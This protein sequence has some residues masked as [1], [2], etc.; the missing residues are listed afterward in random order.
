MLTAYYA[1]IV[2][3]Y[4]D[5]IRNYLLSLLFVTRTTMVA[6]T[7]ILK[8]R[9]QNNLDKS[10]GRDL[11]CHLECLVSVSVLVL[12]L[13]PNVTARSQNQNL[14]LD[15]IWRPKFRRLCPSVSRHAYL[16]IHTSEFHQIFCACHGCGSLLFWQCC[17]ML[18][19]SGFAAHVT[20]APNGQEWARR[21]KAY[22]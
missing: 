16:G 9:Y 20:Y 6:G 3:N 18:C 21:K 7:E 15:L 13:K 22:I 11:G 5:I 19:T 1:D 17:D 12:V 8:S 14:G 2:R 10:F 4:N